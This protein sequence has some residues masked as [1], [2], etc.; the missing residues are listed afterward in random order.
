MDYRSGYPLDR[1]GLDIIGP[2]PQTKRRMEAYHIPQQNAE[3]I[4]DKLV[5]E[6]ISR[7]GVP[8]E[9]HTDQG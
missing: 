6:F 8:L 3:M 2:L 1:I 7:F 5:N 9:V 4:A